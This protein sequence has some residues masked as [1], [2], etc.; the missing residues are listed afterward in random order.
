VYRTGEGQVS[1]RLDSAGA[2]RP[3][4]ASVVAGPAL[5]LPRAPA[6]LDAITAIASHRVAE[7]ARRVD[8]LAEDK[9]GRSPAAS[10]AERDLRALSTE[11]SLPQDSTVHRVFDIGPPMAEYLLIWFA[12]QVGSGPSVRDPFGLEPNSMLRRLVAERLRND[13]G[14]ASA[15]SGVGEA[16]AARAAGDYRS[17][18]EQVRHLAETRLV[19]Q[20]GGDLRHRPE[21]MELLLG[22]EEAVARR[23]DSGLESVVREAL[24][25]YEHLFRRLVAEY[26]PPAQP[27]W[28]TSRP[29]VTTEIAKVALEE[30]AIQLG[31]DPIPAA[32]LTR[33][34]NGVS[35]NPG[36]RSINIRRAFV[37]DL[38]P[39]VLIA[40]VDPRSRY[41]K[42]HPFREL[43]SRQPGLM[44][45]LNNLGQLRN[46]GSHDTRDAIAQDDVEFCRSLAID[47][48]RLLVSM[49]PPPSERN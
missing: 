9:D 21:V 6:P 19:Q 26:P 38:L 39:Y 8:Q 18:A 15:V 16:S 11:L 36:G 32:Y 14:L 47:A 12:D 5:A 46:R 43:A 31:L 2:P 22:F 40:A 45:D 7:L 37:P 20:L 44:T 27:S 34:M 24:R 4:S 48:A 33:S 10:T 23:G 25:K 35:R 41:R 49:P 17:A 29:R 28:A 13:P 42:N 3:I 30:A 1:L